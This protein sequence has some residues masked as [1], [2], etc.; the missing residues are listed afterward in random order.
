M[1]KK[2]ISETIEQV[3]REMVLFQNIAEELEFSEDDIQKQI[4]LYLD[5]LNKLK[6]QLKKATD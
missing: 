6:E 3:K 1:T 5:T 4:D 2:E